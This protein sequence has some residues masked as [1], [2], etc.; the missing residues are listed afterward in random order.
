MGTGTIGSV[1]S[2]GDDSTI[3]KMPNMIRETTTRGYDMVALERA[4]S[5]R[6]F[7]EVYDNVC[8]SNVIKR[9]PNGK[10]TSVKMPR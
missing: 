7:A 2:L 10:R 3:R 1:V 4:Y 5:N 8:Q 9:N 6:M